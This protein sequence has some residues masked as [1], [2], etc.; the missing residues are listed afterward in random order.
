MVFFLINLFYPRN[1]DFAKSTGKIDNILGHGRAGD[2][3]T[4]ALKKPQTP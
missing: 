2:L 1:G 4:K 3:T